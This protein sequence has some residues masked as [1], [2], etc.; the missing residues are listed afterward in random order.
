MT[1]TR[2]RNLIDH[3]LTASRSAV[4]VLDA[5]RRVKFFSPGFAAQTGW[6]PEEVEG[7][8]CD[9]VPADDRSAVEW[10]TA[11]LTPAREVLEGHVQSV[12]TVLP[13]SGGLLLNTM[14]T[15]V[16][17]M[18]GA[19]VDRVLVLSEPESA[20]LALRS[21][22]SQK[23]HA[24]I[25]ALR[26]EFRRRFSDHSFL[27][28]CPAIRRA[29]DQAELLKSS[30]CG[31][32]LVGPSGSG[33][34]HLARMIHVAGQQ[35]EYSFVTLN[36]RLLTADQLLGTLQTL[37]MVSDSA[38]GTAHQRVGTCL[39]LDA[40]QCPREV[41]QW[42]LQN[43]RKEADG[44]RLAA[45]SEL[46]LNHPENE[47]WVIPEFRELFSAVQIDLPSLHRR[48]QDVL[49]LAQHFVEESRRTERTSAESIALDVQ[50][51][52]M[53]YRWPGNVRELKNVITAACQ[54]CFSHQLQISDL[55]F[56]F[57]TG[58]DAQQLPPK[59]LQQ[60]RSLDDLLQQFEKDILLNTILACRGNK[61]EAAR[62]L[63]LTR[64]KLYRRLAALGLDVD[65]PD[66][67]S[68]P[69]HPP[70]LP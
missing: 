53:F 44:I 54:T 36:C 25:T 23:L 3:V 13:K 37:R 16:P 58:M 21:S 63:G 1:G 38:G 45:S 7:L 40:D 19:A 34:R 60:V 12:Q 31:F 30:R 26:L 47:A 42:L 56:I 6:K 65:D 11:A 55:P 64:P 59:P 22:V 4:C 8:L 14:L 66:E 5:D 18:D 57:R 32:S 43:L 67:T 49:I 50:Q 46:P 51:E 35:A 48:E 2:K 24:E 28:K 61:A 15:F 29:L 52:L 69:D 70:A 62:R 17:V 68:P 27:G 39:L 41:Q 9:P 33:R 10:L 20:S